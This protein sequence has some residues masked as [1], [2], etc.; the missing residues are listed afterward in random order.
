MRLR[1]SLFALSI[2]A[3]LVPGVARA[4]TVTLKNGREI[5]GRLVEE[6]RDSIRMRTDDRGT[7]TIPKADIASFTEGEVLVNYGAGGRPVEPAPPA[8]PAQPAQPEPAAP[9]TPA[10]PAAPG[11]PGEWQWPA[12]LTP[13]QIEE[14]TPIRDKVLEDLEKLGPTR[15]ERLKAVAATPEERSE[16]QEQMQ[17]FNY[18]RRR[19]P[20]RG[21]GSAV[22][23]RRLAKERVL[24]HGLKALP[25]LANGLESEALF[26]KQNC[27]VGVAELMQPS[28]DLKLEDL[29]W[30]MYHHDVPTKLL[31]LLDHQGEIESCFVR[32]DGDAALR[33]V[34]GH[35]V[36]YEAS[37]E[38][39]RTLEETRAKTAWEQWWQREKA[40]WTRAEAEKEKTRQE[41]EAKLALL[42]QGKNP[43]ADQR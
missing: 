42:R 14:L 8:Q 41:L 1:R 2:A 23:Q 38:R 29:R 18:N 17:R 22:Q 4:D 7:I 3:A 26:T 27:A 15:E 40:R 30:L 21:Q 20:D 9:A 10:R 13:A 39:M 19:G 25:L 16:I 32:A 35:N 33:V 24:A 5:H 11:R 28:G 37:T 36:N 34:T 43:E 12:G 6:G 31:K